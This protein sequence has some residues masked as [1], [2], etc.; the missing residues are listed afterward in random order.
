M[1]RAALTCYRRLCKAVAQWRGEH[2][3]CRGVNPGRL[4][5]IIHRNRQA[6]VQVDDWLPP[7][8]MENS[9]FR[10]GV[11]PQVERLLNL[12]LDDECTH[13]DL[14]AYFG[15]TV[16]QPC[17]Y[18][19]LGVSVGKTLWQILNTCGPCECWG[20]DIEEI[21]PVLKQ[22]LIQQS[23]EEWPSPPQS[24]KSGS[25]SISRFVHAAS[26]S[27]IN[28][29]CADIFD[30]QAWKLLAGKGFNLV[31]SDAL[32]TPQALDFEWRQM[33][34]L[35][36]F[37]PQET[38]IMWDDLDGEMRDW[39]CAKQQAI[40]KHL[41]VDAGQVETLLLNGWFGR[42]EFPHRLGLGVKMP[43]AVSR[44]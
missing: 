34:T 15:C 25:A 39:F 20:F 7:G 32:H 23:R 44:V 17:R 21:T 22:R 36:I 14:L 38:I 8:L 1:N 18:L 27:N 9:V 19:E 26:G 4:Q 42:R 6:L 33:T 10:Y 11:N 3:L 30:E 24:I 28:Y 12:P 41:A 31:L 40:A 2:F 16:K 5:E 29:I 13:A 43:A 37:D 35:N